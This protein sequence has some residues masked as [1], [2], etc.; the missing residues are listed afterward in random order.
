[1]ST[2][3]GRTRYEDNFGFYDLV[4]SDELAFFH[5]IRNTSVP[6][7]CVRCKEKVKLLPCNKMCG[8]CAEAL[9]FGA[10]EVGE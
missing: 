4:D 1:M 3:S 7:K 10:E 5:H 9:E 6:K 2:A 8:R